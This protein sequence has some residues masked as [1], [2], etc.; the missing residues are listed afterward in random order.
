[1]N[2]MPTVL[3]KP[4]PIAILLAVILSLTL[5][6]WGTPGWAEEAPAS[7]SSVFEVHCVGC[8][9]NGGNIVRRGK[10]LKLAALKRRGYDSVEAIADLVYQGK[11]LMS[12]YG[13][14]LTPAEIQAVSAYVLAQ[15]EQQW[16]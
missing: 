1:M 6:L 16:P 5:W 15:A 14:R 3:S 11:G 9:I 7:G 2:P 10:T 13:D 12:A 8:H 4:S